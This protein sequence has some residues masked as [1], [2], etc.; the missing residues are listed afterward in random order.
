MPTEARIGDT[1]AS[2][3][4]SADDPWLA[5]EPVSGAEIKICRLEPSTGEIVCFIRVPAGKTVAKHYH[6]GTVQLYTIAGKWTYGEGW[7]AEPGDV[8]YETAGSTHAPTMIGNKPTILF[9]VIQG[10]FEFVDDANRLISR[11]TWKDLKNLYIEHCA[12]NGLG[13]GLLVALM[14]HADFFL[15]VVKRVENVIELKSGQPKDGFNALRYYRIRREFRRRSLR[16]EFPC[17]SI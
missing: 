15:T 3:I 9:A 6:A 11:C 8:V 12:K 7:E 14:N 5:W 10:G 16:S 13:R 4:R 1:V 2:F 17:Y